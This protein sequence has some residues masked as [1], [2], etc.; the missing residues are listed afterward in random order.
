MIVLIHQNRGEIMS[1]QFNRSWLENKFTEIQRRT[2]QVV[3]QLDDTKLNWKPNENSNSISNLIIH[4]K[5]NIEERIGSGI[6]SK[7]ITRIRE[8]EFDHQFVS[9]EELLYMVKTYFD[10]LINTVST[11]SDIQLEQK[12]IIRNRE[13]SNLDVLHQCAVHFSE[14]MGQI[15]YIAKMHLNK[16]YKTTS[17]PRPDEIK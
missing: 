5:G 9:K 7:E 11:L 8:Q 10:L 1:Y 2:L 6:H 15:L 14:H 3:E 17:I 13:R 16:E 12:Q 4:I